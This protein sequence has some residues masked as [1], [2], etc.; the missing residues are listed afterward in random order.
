MRRSSRR[1][2]RT[3]R[4]GG[5]SLA[6]VCA[7]LLAAVVLAAP[8]RAAWT[9]PVDVS[10]SPATAPQ[11]AIDADGDAVFVWT[12][13]EISGCECNRI[14][15]RTRWADGTWSGGPNLSTSA[16]VADT[17]RSQ[18]AVDA[19]GDAVF[20]WTRWDGANYRIQA[21]A[22]A[23]NGALS[24]VQT[25][26][27]AGQDAGE[28]Q[29]AIDADGDAVFAWTRL[30]GTN[31]RIQARGRT[32]AGSLS[33]VQT[34][35]GAGQH[36]DGAQVAVDA[37]GD[38]VLTWQR[39][40]GTD[41]RVQARARSSAGTLGGVQTLSGAGHSAGGAQVAVDADGDAVFAWQ[42]FN[43]SL[44]RIQARA[45]AAD[46]TLSPVQGLSA[47]PNSAFNPQLGV[48]ASGNAVF[49]WWRV[50]NGLNRVQARARDAGGALAAIE[51]LTGPIASGS[52]ELP[53]PQVGVDSD[54]DSVF[55]WM[56]EDT[57]GNVLVQARARSAAGVLG[58]AGALSAAGQDSIYPQVAVSPGGS[59]VAA[60]EAGSS[61]SNLIQAAFG[62]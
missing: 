38:A 13:L 1:F 56:E 53:L 2:G 36:A 25:L 42:R 29:V 4:R 18:V 9:G 30:D 44:W 21:R 12:A 24:P 34:L 51:D 3:A 52:P 17:F 49:T 58:P 35:S 23:A 33:A 43:G 48:D 39:F 31:N 10:G 19:D 32:A 11:V 22:R 54:G 40:D 55:V 46:G 37:D 57:S 41:Y 27:G 47:G 28:P 26:S 16:G 7:S 14:Q 59:A 61:T 6:F 20:T 62:P 8:A 15:T 50:D 45:R 60:W 5:Q